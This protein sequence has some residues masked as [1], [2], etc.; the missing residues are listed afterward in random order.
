MSYKKYLIITLMTGLFLL[1]FPLL[2][3][4]SFVP[5]N[6]DRNVIFVIFMNGTY[7]LTSFVLILERDRL[8]ELKFNLFAA[9]IFVGA[10]IIRIFAYQGLRITTAFWDLWFPAGLSVLMGIFFAF[11]YKRLHKD[12]VRYYIKWIIVSALVGALMAIISSTVDVM[13]DPQARSSMQATFTVLVGAFFIQ[14]ANAAVSEEPLFR[15]FLWGYLEK[16][17]WR[18]KRILFFQAGLFCLGHIYY[19]PDNPIYFLW[20]FIIPL[21]LG[22]LV[23]KSKSVGSSM[24]AHGIVN[25]LSDLI[26]H[27]SW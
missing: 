13:I 11:N 8:A 18:Q 22:L 23:M 6:V 16:K 17:G 2:I 25:S 24:I 1:R 27:Y 15:G 7:L 5:M 4:V 10:S 21:F 26:Q 19:L 12:N 14:I 9:V 20:A 3:I